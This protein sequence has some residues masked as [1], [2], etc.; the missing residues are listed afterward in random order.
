MRNALSTPAL[1]ECRSDQSLSLPPCFCLSLSL[2]LSLPLPSRF[3]LS[4]PVSLSP[5]LFLS[6]SHPVSLSLSLPD[7]QRGCVRACFME[8]E[9]GR[10]R[11][12][13]RGREKQGGRGRDRNRE[14]ERDWSDRR[15]CGRAQSIPHSVSLRGYY[16]NEQ[17]YPVFA[18]S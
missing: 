15:K 8:K 2:F 6:L 4:L 12:E 9:R 18:G 1:S 5:T 10:E 11:Q 13:G 17:L 14:G 7:R 3:S 16:I